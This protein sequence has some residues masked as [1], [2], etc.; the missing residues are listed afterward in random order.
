MSSLLRHERL[1]YICC[2][3]RKQKN[4]SCSH[5]HRPFKTSS[6]SENNNLIIMI[7]ITII[8]M[9]S[10]MITITTKINIGKIIITRSSPDHHR[11]PHHQHH[12]RH[13]HRHHHHHHDHD[14]HHHHHYHHRCSH[15]NR[16]CQFLLRCNATQVLLSHAIK[17]ISLAVWW[18]LSPEKIKTREKKQKR[19][20]QTNCTGL[21]LRCWKKTQTCKWQNLEFRVSN[22]PEFS[23]SAKS[24]NQFHYEFNCSLES[25]T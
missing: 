25:H 17:M 2:M 7:I 23:I 22:M 12:H 1:R 10:I 6:T 15:L 5:H 9:I 19:K 24:M 3:N 11:P 8:L 16:N 18:G 13:R 21:L 4:Y 20:L 14:H